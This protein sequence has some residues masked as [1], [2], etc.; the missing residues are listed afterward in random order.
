MACASTSHRR[1][2]GTGVVMAR[3]VGCFGRAGSG[4]ILFWR[5]RL[6]IG[7]HQPSLRSGSQPRFCGSEH[8]GVLASSA[9][10]AGPD[11]D[12]YNSPTVFAVCQACIVASMK[13]VKVTMPEEL[14]APGDRGSAA[15]GDIQVRVDPAGAGGNPA[16]GEL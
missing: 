14:D 13:A 10:A 16:C 15:A 9:A 1:P 5:C 6:W 4:Q 12:G 3:A 2:L 8:Q 11:P 7:S